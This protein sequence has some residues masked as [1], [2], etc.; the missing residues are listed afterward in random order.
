MLLLLQ[1][2]QL[3]WNVFVALTYPYTLQHLLGGQ[4][5]TAEAMWPKLSGTSFTRSQPRRSR[6]SPIS[7]GS[8]FGG[9]NKKLDV[10]SASSARPPDSTVTT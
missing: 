10:W 1:T 6:G 2:L 8:T 9:H 3:L 4:T 5:Y 7:Q